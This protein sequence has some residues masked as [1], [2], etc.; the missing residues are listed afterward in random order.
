LDHA[1][2]DSLISLDGSLMNTDV[3]ADGL[4]SESDLFLRN[5]AAFNGEVTLTG[6]RIDN[7]VNMTDANF[8]GTLNNESLQIGGDLRMR[9]ASYNEV[10][11]AGAKI[12]GQI[13]MTGASFDDTLDARSLGVGGDLLMSADQNKARFKGVD[14]SGA[15]ILG[16][17]DMQGATFG[18]MLTANN[19]QVSGYLSLAHATCTDEVTMTAAHL[20]STLDLR[21][22][23]LASLDL[24]DTTVVAALQLGGNDNSVFWKRKNAEPATLSLSDA[25]VG[26][27]EDAMDAWMEKNPEQENIL[28]HLN[29]FTFDHLA[30][31][32]SQLSNREGKGMAW[33]ASWAQHDP[34]Y[35]P[36]PYTQ[37]ANVFTAMGDRDAA[38]EIRYLGR[39]AGREAACTQNK[40]SFACLLH[41]TL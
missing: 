33:W 31:S 13:D 40:W 41:W 34:Q 28:L 39:E 4:H 19:L 24:S 36:T 32:G 2:T 6:A 35:S 3:T 16:R 25:H 17:L 38:N 10:D 30:E 15:N 29:G 23:T 5:G 12:K 9:K 20:G 22:A 1:H 21:G 37:L 11:L 8:D 27:L 14:L 7:D 26:T 18:G